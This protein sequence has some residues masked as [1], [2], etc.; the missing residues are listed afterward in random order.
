MIDTLALGIVALIVLIL[1]SMDAETA[2]RYEMWP[3]HNQ[4]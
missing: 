1:L 3:P 2:G 4:G